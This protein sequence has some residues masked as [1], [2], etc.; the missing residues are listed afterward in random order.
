M[1]PCET[2]ALRNKPGRT[3]SVAA[4]LFDASNNGVDALISCLYKPKTIYRQNGTW[5]MNSTT[6]SVVRKLKDGEGRYLWEPSVKVDTPNRL[7]GK[8]IVNPESM[9]DKHWLNHAFLILL[10]CLGY[11]FCLRQ[12]AL[13]LHLPFP[14]LQT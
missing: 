13:W 3:L 1:W 7:L 11:L 4:A 12:I 10:L 14:S 5:A 6:E 8:P 9:P 2:H